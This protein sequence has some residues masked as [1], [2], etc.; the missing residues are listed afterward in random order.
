M[1]ALVL[2]PLSAGVEHDDDEDYEAQCE[3]HH[4]GGLIFPNLLYATRKLG[5]IHVCFDV[6]PASLE[7][8]LP[9][10]GIR[11][12]AKLDAAAPPR[13]GGVENKKAA[14]LGAAVIATLNHITGHSL[15]GD[16]DCGMG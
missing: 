14:P 8:K 11:L 12:R 1:L 7:N 5:P 6:T 16:G 2:S 15:H 4:Y 13:Q 3:E 9:N 10:W